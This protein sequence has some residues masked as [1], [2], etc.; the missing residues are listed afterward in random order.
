MLTQVRNDYQVHKI[1][2]NLGRIH[3]PLK[4]FSRRNHELS[5]PNTKFKKL[6]TTRIV[7]YFLIRQSQSVTYHGRSD[8]HVQSTWCVL[9]IATRREFTQLCRDSW[10]FKCVINNYTFKLILPAV[11]SKLTEKWNNNTVNITRIFSII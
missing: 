3:K 4:Y 9:H 6:C 7:K 11:C 1:T 5:L 8:E 10:F 2:H